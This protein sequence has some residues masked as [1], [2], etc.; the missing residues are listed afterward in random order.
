M[1]FKAWVVPSFS[2]FVACAQMDNIQNTYMMN[3][4]FF[5]F[6]EGADFL[7][8]ENG[9]MLHSVKNFIKPTLSNLSRTSMVE[10]FF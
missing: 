1:G 3:V 9:E 6:F 2:Y 8:G 10:G 5:F 4:S 7:E